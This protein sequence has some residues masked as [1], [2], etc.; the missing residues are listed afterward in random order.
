VKE[1]VGAAVA[2]GSALVYDVGYVLEK[3][4]LDRL[5]SFGP[6]PAAVLRVARISRRWLVGFAAMLAGL[7][8]Q[9]VALTL[10][11][12]SVVQPILAG[13][14][15]ALAVVGSSLLG[16]RLDRRHRVA[17]VLIMMAVVSVALSAS[18]SGRL[19][20]SVAGGRLVVLAVVVVVLALLAARAGARTGNRRASSAD[21]GPPEWRLSPAGLVGTALAAGLFYGLGALSEKAVATNLVNNGFLDGA[22]GALSTAYP[23]VFLAVTLSGMLLFQVGLQNNPASL[24]ASLTNVTST[25]CALV[26]ASVVFGEAVFPDSW[27]SVVRVAGFACGMAAVGLLA[28]DGEA[29]PASASDPVGAD[30]T[31][32]DRAVVAVIAPVRPTP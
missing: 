9:V 25:V 6:R 3:Q 31:Q 27:W 12:V 20:R 26:G 23:W 14:L 28:F 22:V 19:A 10:A 21:A 18:E 15:I 24:M 4:A 8:L 29:A 5:P 1:L 13:G 16:E 17:L 11:P 30:R 2:V 32:A 7:G